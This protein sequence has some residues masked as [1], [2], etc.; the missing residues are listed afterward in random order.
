MSLWRPLQTL[1]RSRWD[2]RK[3]QRIGSLLKCLNHT[4]LSINHLTSTLRKK[5]N[6]LL[7]VL[8]LLKRLKWWKSRRL[9]RISPRVLTSWMT[10]L[11]ATTGTDGKMKI[12]KWRKTSRTSLDMPYQCLSYLLS[13]F[14][15]WIVL[16]P[17]KNKIP[18]ITW[19]I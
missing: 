18:Y 3:Q 4:Q 7:A 10:F 15:E 6:Q 5:P 17:E 1:R 2:R 13:V 12:S 19:P 16:L 14:E 9:S 11:T 8:P